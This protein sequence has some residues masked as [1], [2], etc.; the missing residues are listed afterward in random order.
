M[1]QINHHAGL[2][3]IKNQYAWENHPSIPEDSDK[4]AWLLAEKRKTETESAPKNK[5]N[6]EKLFSAP[7]MNVLLGK[8][9][10]SE[11]F[12]DGIIDYISLKEKKVGIT[13]NNGKKSKFSYPELFVKGCIKIKDN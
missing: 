4:Y 3:I 6:K 8:N 7:P 2:H 5:V 13:F 10:E 1:A 9:I 11:K 12:G